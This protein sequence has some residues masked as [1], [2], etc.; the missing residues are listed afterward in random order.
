MSATQNK[1]LLQRLFADLAEGNSRPFIDAL[2]DDFRWVIAGSSCWSRTYEGKQVVLN[3]FFPL[4]RST[5][6]DRVRTRATRFIADG[7]HVVVEARGNNTTRGGM[8]YNN[9]YCLVYT[10]RE[11]RIREVVEYMDTDLAIKAL[12]D[13]AAIAA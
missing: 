7:D 10:V 12:G 13:P 6:A 11:G 4:L 8:P 9:S 3:E 5:I 1:Q 2:A